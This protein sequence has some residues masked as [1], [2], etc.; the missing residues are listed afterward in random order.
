LCL[1]PYL[2]TSSE[3]ELFVKGVKG[4][5]GEKTVSY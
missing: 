1:Q 4:E 5:K 3:K 2:N